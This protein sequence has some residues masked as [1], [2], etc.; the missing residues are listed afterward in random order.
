MVKR[1]SSL[2]S[3]KE[4]WVRVLVGALRLLQW[5]VSIDFLEKVQVRIEH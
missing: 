2:A 5:V 1:K 4:F 3:N